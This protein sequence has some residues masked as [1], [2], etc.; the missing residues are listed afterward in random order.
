M[1]IVVHMAE[2]RFFFYSLRPDRGAKNLQKISKKCSQF[3]LN[4]NFL[5]LSNNNGIVYEFI[6]F[7]V[8]KMQK[9]SKNNSQFQ[10]NYNLLGLNNNNNNRI[11]TRGA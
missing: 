4:Y 10:L 3:Q 2:Q 7:F 5:G 8:L 9:I 6:E 11:V 1:L